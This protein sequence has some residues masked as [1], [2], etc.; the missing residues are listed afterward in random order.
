MPR[1][2]GNSPGKPTSLTGSRPAR[3]SGVRA[4]CTGRLYPSGYCVPSRRALRRAKR[5]EAECDQEPRHQQHVDADVVLAGAD[6][7]QVRCDTRT[8]VDRPGDRR[9]SRSRTTPGVQRS[10]GG[11]LV[12]REGRYRWSFPSQP[13]GEY[14]RLRLR[15]SPVVVKFAFPSCLD[16][17]HVVR[18]CLHHAYTSKQAEIG[19]ERFRLRYVAAHHR[20]HRGARAH[21]GRNRARTAQCCGSTARVEGSIEGRPREGE[22]AIRQEAG[23]YC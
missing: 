16:G 23:R 5:G 19:S 17:W 2:K 14:P 13:L 6:D 10:K 12:E 1:V 4:P 20:T 18:Y 11:A 7:A 9:E 3:S 8:R 15:R 21:A 22:V